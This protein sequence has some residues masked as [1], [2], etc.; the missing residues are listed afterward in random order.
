MAQLQRDPVGRLLLATMDEAEV[1]RR[2]AATDPYGE[3]AALAEAGRLTGTDTA[4]LAWLEHRL[5]CAK[6]RALGPERTPLTVVLDGEEALAETE[7]R[8]TLLVPVL[9]LDTADAI[10]VLAHVVRDRPVVV[11]GEDVSRTDIAESSVEVA[12][13]DH[14]I[15]GVLD[16]LDRGGIYATY[17]DFVYEG[18]GSLPVTLFG[19]RR[20]MSRGWVGL[21]A[22]DG[23]MIL[24]V[25]IVRDGDV[26]RV[27]V[28]E[29]TLVSGG[30]DLS[31]LADYLARVMEDLIRPCPAQWLLLPTLTFESADLAPLT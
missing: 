18:R 29:P 9:T 22:R 11:F 14:E 12:E 17:G 27:R 2:I 21:A 15:R 3:G 26:A 20:P 19:R 31:V 6:R 16:V 8:P 1:A 28:E 23:T 30:G 5:W 10:D 25:G 13:G 4:P 24:P 7:G